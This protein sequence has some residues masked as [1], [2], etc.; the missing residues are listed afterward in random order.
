MTP[1]G[2]F[3][4]ICETQVRLPHVGRG[5]WLVKP[6][7]V[8]PNILDTGRHPCTGKSLGLYKL[9][10]SYYSILAFNL[11]PCGV[12]SWIC[13]LLLSEKSSANSNVQCHYCKC[14]KGQIHCRHKSHHAYAS[15]FGKINY[16]IIEQISIFHLF[17]NMLTLNIQEKPTA[18]GAWKVRKR[19]LT[20]YFHDSFR[21]ILSQKYF[22]VD[23][24]RILPLWLLQMQA[25]VWPLESSQGPVRLLEISKMYGR[26]LNQ[27]KQGSLF[28]WRTI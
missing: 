13:V 9:Y 20:K 6:P 22:H 3:H 17:R 2:G 21:R 1:A 16:L 26:A 8:L 4:Q 24:R 5:S 19:T 10:K 27:A 18:M 28:I 7:L 25:R 11:W 14:E 23:F 12:I 15:G